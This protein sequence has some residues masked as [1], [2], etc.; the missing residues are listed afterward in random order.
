MSDT[1]ITPGG[2]PIPA[3]DLVAVDGETMGGTG[4]V[5]DPLHVIDAG[6]PS[7]VVGGPNASIHAEGTI[8]IAGDTSV[9]LTAETTMTLDAHSDLT[10]QSDVGAVQVASVA[11]NVLLDAGNNI[12]I[13]AVG[14]IACTSDKMG[15]FATPAV[16]RPTGV[17]VNAAAI[18]AALVSL[19]LITA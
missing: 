18:H 3:G 4:S 5:Y 6:V 17:G 14:S 10:L 7:T 19:G 9:D 16:V 13:Q 8:V 12:V 1:K 15:F 11:S 2:S